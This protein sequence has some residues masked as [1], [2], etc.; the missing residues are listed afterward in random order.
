[1]NDAVIVFKNERLQTGQGFYYGPAP[2]TD[3][4]LFNYLNI[5]PTYVYRPTL[6]KRC[7]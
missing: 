1:M 2:G 3:L 7:H 4:L 6:C 5:K